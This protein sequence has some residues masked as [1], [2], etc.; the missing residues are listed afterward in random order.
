MTL[1]V[2]FTELTKAK[3]RH[4]AAAQ[5]AQDDNLKDAFRILNDVNAEADGYLT[6]QQML[7]LFA[8]LNKYHDIQWI[9]ATMQMAIFDRLDAAHNEV[10]NEEEFLQLCSILRKK[11]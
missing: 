2:V 11:F 1:G 9:D 10:I 3:E 4:A 6:L 5:A 8:E 7:H